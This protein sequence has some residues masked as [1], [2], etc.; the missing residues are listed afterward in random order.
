[1]VSPPYVVTE[2]QIDSLVDCLHQAIIAE[3]AG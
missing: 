3:A 1:M 2:E